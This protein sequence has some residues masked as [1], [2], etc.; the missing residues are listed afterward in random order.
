MDLVNRIE[1]YEN[2]NLS[3]NTI[4]D[5]EYINKYAARAL[6]NGTLINKSYFENST[7]QNSDIE[8]SKFLKS[9]FIQSSFKS[10]DI[11]STLAKE[12]VFRNVNF[13]NAIINDCTFEDCIFLN[14][15][16]EDVSLSD[17]T[18]TRCD[19]T[20]PSLSHGSFTLN[21]FNNCTFENMTFKNVFY[22]SEFNNCNFK[23]VFFEAYLLGYSNGL[24]TE[25]FKQITF[26]LMGE[27]T[28]DTYE[29]IFEKIKNI[30]LERYMYI[31][32]G[33]LALYGANI[34][35]DK[36]LLACVRSIEEYIKRDYLLKKDQ[37]L[38]LKKIVNHM[39]DKEQIIPITIILIINYINI[40]LETYENIALKKI[41]T[42]L[43]SFKNDLVDIY[44]IFTNM[45]FEKAMDYNEKELVIIKLKYLEKPE[46]EIVNLLNQIMPDESAPILIKTQN[47]SFIEWIQCTE[48]FIACLDLFLSLMGIT[49]PIVYE[50]F[51]K[52]NSTPQGS[53]SEIIINNYVPIGAEDKILSFTNSINQSVIAATNKNISNSVKVIINNNFIEDENLY[54]YNKKNIKEIK[55]KFN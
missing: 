11:R 54:G 18:F 4:K 21:D 28:N 42:E 16:F 5:Q 22:Y 14:C 6:L 26:L 19:F 36:A 12:T 8:G 27:E 33:L 15:N 24:S 30:Y 44:M 35:K 20:L 31:N 39:Y 50:K 25:N 37:I 34:S 10:S 2:V 29:V 46:K 48:N 9:H 43:N 38:F 41:S 53:E 49:I 3:F 13:S 51:K 47:G 45:L 17:T 23:N 55:V 52:K 32:A 7:F 40:I 1:F